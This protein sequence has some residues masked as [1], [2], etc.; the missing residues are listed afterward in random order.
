MKVGIMKT[1]A[2]LLDRVFPQSVISKL[3]QFESKTGQL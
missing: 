2:K 3:L 1:S